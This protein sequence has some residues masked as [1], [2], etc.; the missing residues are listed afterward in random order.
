MTSDGSAVKHSSM[1]ADAKANADRLWIERG[2]F[3]DP[4]NAWPIQPRLVEMKPRGYC[5]NR[6]CVSRPKRGWDVTVH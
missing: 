3:S 1:W 6:L 4:R 5:N 2:H